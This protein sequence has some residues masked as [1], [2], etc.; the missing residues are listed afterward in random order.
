MV[1]ASLYAV[2]SAFNLVVIDDVSLEKTKL[3]GTLVVVVAVKLSVAPAM[4]SVTVF[5]LDVMAMP[6]TLKV[7]STADCNCL[8]KLTPV[9][10]TPPTPCVRLVNEKALLAPV[11]PVTMMRKGVAMLPVLTS[12]AEMP[13]LAELMAATMPAG[14]VAVAATAMVF[15]N[16]VPVG[17][18]MSSLLLAVDVSVTTPLLLTPEE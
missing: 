1:L 13:K 6:F 8:P 18:A 9:T 11:A 14:V 5:L 7:A 3:A 4:A 10:S 2:T 15:E 17:A 12:C 16:W